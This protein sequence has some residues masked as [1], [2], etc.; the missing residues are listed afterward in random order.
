[1]AQVVSLQSEGEEEEG[2]KRKKEEEEGGGNEE[3]LDK[4]SRIA[5]RP[6]RSTKSSSDDGRL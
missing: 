1:M 2:E 6:T 5:E 4:Q 3:R